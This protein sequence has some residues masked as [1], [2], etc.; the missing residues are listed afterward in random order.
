MPGTVYHLQTL[1]LTMVT[2]STIAF[3]CLA[4][5]LLRFS[6]EF[7]ESTRSWVVGT[8]L[9]VTADVIFFFAYD[10]PYL[11]GIL[12]IVAGAGV[13]EWIHALRRYNGLPGRTWWP[14]VTVAIGAT[15][16][17]LVPS[18]PT[19]VLVTSV[20]YSVLYIGAA[21]YASMIEEPV[22]STGRALLI[23]VFVLIAVVM[24]GRLA[25]FVSGVRSGA[26]E[27]FTSLVRALMFVVASVAPIA[28]SLAFVITVG[29]RLGDRLLHWS[30]TDPLTGMANRRALFD[31][32]NRELSSSRRH[33]EPVSLIVIDLD[34]FKRVNDTAGHEAG[35]QALAEVGRVIRETA[36][37]EDSVGRL[38]GE[39]FAVVVPGADLASALRAA[40]R[41]REALASTPIA[42][43]GRVFNLT[44]SMGVAEWD[45]KEE[46]SAL[47]S[48]A[49]RLLYQAKDSGRD[50]VV[51]EPQEPPPS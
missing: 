33:A 7:R 11:H 5:A 12:T 9:V 50:L 31:A 17:L 2:V 44:A 18:Y 20:L 10:L 38:G 41:L 51:F 8:A 6:D 16:S 25:L 19:S 29:E 46:P 39:E 3:L 42:A 43:G 48:R 40:E 47:M 45:G 26:P 28:A 14:Y 13:A 35:D 22:R 37:A 15:I 24:T 30:L 23:V 21:R 32:M 34:H 27:G 1:A 36:R 4:P 49:D